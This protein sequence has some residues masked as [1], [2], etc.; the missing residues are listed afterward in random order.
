MKKAST[1]TRGLGLAGL[2]LAGN[3][4]EVSVFGRLQGLFQAALSGS[5]GSV[6]GSQ[7][8]SSRL[9]S[10][11]REFHEAPLAGLEHRPRQLL[12][13]DVELADRPAVE[14]HASLADQAA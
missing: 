10:G 5:R 11:L 14:L 4:P 9:G 6:A 1:R 7:R 13:R 8:P 12:P 3:P 2:P